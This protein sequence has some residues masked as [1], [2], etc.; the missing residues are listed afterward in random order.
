M[1]VKVIETKPDQSVVKR[2]I[3]KSCGATLEYVPNDVQ[4]YSG[5]DRGG[6]PDGEEWVD[7]PNCTKKVTIRSW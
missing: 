2:I 3:C 6:G 4:I 5:T 7:C 1:T